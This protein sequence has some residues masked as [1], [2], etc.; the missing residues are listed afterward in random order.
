[1]KRHPRQKAPAVLAA[2]PVLLVTALLF[3]VPPL[4][5]ETRTEEEIDT[6]RF[7]AEEPEDPAVLPAAEK[8][9]DT[10]WLYLGLRAGPSLR[11]YTPSDDT[12]YTGNDTLS[13]ALDIALQANLQVLSFLSVQTEAVFTWD[14][15]SLWAYIGPSLAADYDYRYTVDYT[16][17]SFQFPFILKFDFFPGR[18]R[19]SPFAGMY[20]L[21]P[22]GELESSVSLNNEKE[23]SSYEIFPSVGF[24]GGLSGAAKFGP[25]MIIADLRYAADLGDFKTGGT[26]LFNRSMI[27]ITVGYELGF[28]TK[29]KGGRP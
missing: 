24:L 17:F 7:G 29:G 28:F 2:L 14:N 23:F 3:V 6:G 22:L 8:G 13:V 18:F 27:S 26:E 12:P 11:F 1:M 20:C 19:L 10:D 15:A 9:L 21:V 4:S 25:G 16:A 5:A